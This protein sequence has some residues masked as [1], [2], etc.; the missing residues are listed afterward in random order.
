MAKEE[1]NPL[2]RVKVIQTLIA[3]EGTAA[4]ATLLDL[5]GD[6]NAL[7]RRAVVEGLTGLGDANEAA[8]LT[9]QNLA[10]NDM[11]ETVRAAAQKALH[12]CENNKMRASGLPTSLVA[13]LMVPPQVL[14]NLLVLISALELWRQSLPDLA[15]SRSAEEICELDEALNTILI[16]LRETESLVASDQESHPSLLD[17]EGTT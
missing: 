6:T 15:G 4:E 1:T 11:E 17:A 8:F 2:L 16:T 14:P 3:L 10:E 9:L 13:D 5:A 7:V 12:V